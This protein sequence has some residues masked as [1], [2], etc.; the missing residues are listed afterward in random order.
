MYF[1]N[2]KQLYVNKIQLLFMT[3]LFIKILM[4]F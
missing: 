4:Q 3:K 1:L 2:K